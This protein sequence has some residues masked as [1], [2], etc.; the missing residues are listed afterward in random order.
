MSSASI[1]CVALTDHEVPVAQ[2][3]GALIDGAVMKPAPWMHRTRVRK[4]ARQCLPLPRSPHDFDNVLDL[5]V[6]HDLLVRRL[7]HIE[8]LTLERKNCGG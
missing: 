2:S 7:A 1:G 8:E 6:C 5:S 3:L 4:S